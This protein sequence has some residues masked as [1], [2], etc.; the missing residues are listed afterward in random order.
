LSPSILIPA[1]SAGYFLLISYATLTLAFEITRDHW[2]I[3]SELFL[4]TQKI[5]ALSCSLT[6]TFFLPLDE[7]VQNALGEPSSKIGEGINDSISWREHE[8]VYP[9]PLPNNP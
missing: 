3:S 9:K 1:F 4:K 2:R 7:V 5:L 6:K 8:K